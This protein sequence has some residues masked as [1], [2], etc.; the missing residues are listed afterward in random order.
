MYVF[1]NVVAVKC[2]V[3]AEYYLCTMLQKIG[4]KITP[5]FIY[6]FSEVNI[7]FKT[8]SV[9]ISFER[10]LLL[11]GTCL[12][13]CFEFCRILGFSGFHRFLVTTAKRR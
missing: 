12:L 9:K 10:R 2:L 5:L 1:S 8:I 13:L 6:H 3:F 7:S 11:S 4:K